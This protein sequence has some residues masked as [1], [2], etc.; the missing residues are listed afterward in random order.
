M[1]GAV[2]SL[3]GICNNIGQTG[4]QPHVAATEGSE[5]VE[6]L[7]ARGIPVTPMP[8]LPLRL[9]SPWRT[10]RQLWRWYRLLRKVRP[11]LIH[12]N[13]FNESLAFSW[14]PWLLG[15]PYI[16]HVRFP[17]TRSLVA[18][19]LARVPA[20]RVLIFNSDAM[21]V[22][23]ELLI[24]EFAPGSRQCVLHNGFDF[25]TFPRFPPPPPPYV[26]GMVANFAR[27]KGH[28]DFIR[29]AARVTRELPAVRFLVIGG[30][31]E[32]PL[33]PERL[34]IWAKRLGLNDRVHFIGHRADVPAMLKS[35]HILVH[36]AR[37]E[38]F[39]RVLIEAMAVGRPVVASDDGGPREIVQHGLTGYLVPPGDVDCFAQR[40]IE[41]LKDDALR[42]RMGEAAALEARRRFSLEEH[43]HSLALIYNSV[44]SPRVAEERKSDA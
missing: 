25:A 6:V 31:V 36:P 1:G 13:T 26:V 8:M 12:E 41:L 24:R 42:G 11:R 34:A 20:P 28:R 5:L 3:I 19:T 4:W 40:V 43:V 33:E 9:R 15:I 39:G 27:Y 10:V 7:R 30:V 37:F 16:S 32:D 21:R 2:H 18:Y 29:M 22:R 14:L 23:S 17:L 38:A 44:V 35:I